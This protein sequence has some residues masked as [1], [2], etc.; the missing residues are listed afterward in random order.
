MNKCNTCLFHKK[1][2]HKE[3]CCSCLDGATEYMYDE[4][5]DLRQTLEDTESNLKEAEA[6]I[7]ELEAV[8]KQLFEDRKALTAIVESMV[9]A[10]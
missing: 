9:G 10:K 2:S 1:E 8:G 3:P 6:K 7:K 4:A 5:D